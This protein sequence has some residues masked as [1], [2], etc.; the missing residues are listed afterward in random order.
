MERAGTPGRLRKRAA[1]LGIIAAT[2]VLLV[3]LGLRAYLLHH[4]GGPALV[5]PRSPALESINRFDPETSWVLRAHVQDYPV[6]EAPLPGDAYFPTRHF[7]VSTDALGL[8]R[9]PARQD[10]AGSTVLALGDSTTFGLGVEDGEAWPAQLQ[11]LL[12]ARA[13][14]QWAVHNGGVTGYSLLQ[15]ERVLQRLAPRLRPR[16][17]VL[18]A[19]S[20]EATQSAVPDRHV[21]ALCTSMTRIIG[22]PTTW[23]FL[24]HALY[25]F[26][27]QPETAHPPRVSVGEHGDALRRIHAFCREAG[28]HLVLLRWPWRDQTARAKDGGAVG[29]NWP[30]LA[31]QQALLDFSGQPGVSVVDLLP[32]F[33][34]QPEDLFYD[35][36]HVLPPGN[37]VVA[38]AVAAALDDAP[39]AGTEAP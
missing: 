37:R 18:T 16:A 34:A 11:G 5:T 32:H 1:Q 7:S 17:V 35:A 23:T 26:L 38:D 39:R 36:V 19:G 8:R 12:N 33:A 21:F 4:F 15:S 24:R 30:Q 22:V 6:T 29:D 3:E 14:G 27:S 2:T 20:N 31:Y 28:I 9:V 25:P 13:P 10:G